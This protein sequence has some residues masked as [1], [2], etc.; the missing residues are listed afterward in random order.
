MLEGALQ[1]YHDFSDRFPEPNVADDTIIKR[2]EMLYRKLYRIPGSRRVLEAIDEKVVQDKAG[3]STI[4]EI[5]DPW[6]TVL[7]YRYNRGDS[8]PKLISAGPDRDM[9]VVGDNI[10]NK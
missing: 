9:A 2:C 10:T 8:F 7:D 6:G 1:E 3:P 5:Y 4:P